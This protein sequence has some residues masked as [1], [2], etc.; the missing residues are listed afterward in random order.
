[1]KTADVADAVGD[2]SFRRAVQQN[3]LRAHR[4][5]V[6]MTRR[7]FLVDNLSQTQGKCLDPAIGTRRGTRATPVETSFTPCSLMRGRVTVQ[8][9]T[10]AK[11]GREGL[12][13]PFSQVAVRSEDQLRTQLN[14]ARRA[15]DAGDR[16]GLAGADGRIRQ[17]ELR[18]CSAALKNSPRNW[19][20]K[21]SLM[22][23]SL[24]SE[25]SKFTRPGPYKIFRPG[26]AI[27]EWR[28]RRK[29]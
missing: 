22:R 28:R 18:A 14:L 3:H 17:I 9:V 7:H 20:R 29:R 24:N 13:V 1:M 10:G 8:L 6:L 15:D 23:N 12:P 4:E 19:T 21:P 2:D 11:R 16:P 27:G 26:I 25:K 5:D